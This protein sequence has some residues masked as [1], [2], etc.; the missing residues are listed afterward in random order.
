[1]FNNLL[2]VISNYAHLL[3]R[4]APELEQSRQLQGIERAVA[5]G[6][7]L[8]RQLL[9][10]ARRQ[11]LRA[12]LIN[13]AERIPELVG[14]VKA[15]VGSGITV[16]CDIEPNLPCVVA[17]PAEFELAII[18]L[19]VNS[20]DAMPGG[21]ELRLTAKAASFEGKPAVQ[22]EVADTGTGI[23]PEVAARVFEPFY[24][25]KAV[26]HGTG[27]GLSQVYAF[28]QQAGGDAA[29][30]TAVGEGTAVRITLPAAEGSRAEM[31]GSTQVDEIGAAVSARV[32]LVEDNADLAQP[33]AEL[34]RNT[35]YVVEHAETGD[36][37]IEVLK[38]SSFNVILS[39]VRMPG[40]HD[41]V[42]LT[43]WV[44]QHRPGLGVVLMTGY[45]SELSHAE[46][47]GVPVLPKPAMP[48][49]LLAAVAGAARA[50]SSP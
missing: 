30:R 12:E 33:T 45:T 31:L 21:G 32:L 47:L 39:D 26:G 16:S 5:T 40:R 4:M 1:D 2:M 46:S 6:A 20:R 44:H 50:S 14:L 42:A 38:G 37:A 29:L 15:S 18:N 11:P 10:F 34:L 19:A 24:T 17:D 49:A 48:S 43:R 25:T 36:E 8:T 7:R 35:G 23:P 9:A 3:R 27:L 41:G 28:A 22:I 13:V